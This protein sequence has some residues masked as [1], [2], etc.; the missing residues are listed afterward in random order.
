[1]ISKQAVEEFR[2]IYRNQYGKELSDTEATRMANN[3]IRVYKAVLRP[4]TKQN[5]ESD[6]KISLI[7]N[8][9]CE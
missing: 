8:L 9:P 4:S 6:N 5:I 1:M 7:S 2:T 3:L